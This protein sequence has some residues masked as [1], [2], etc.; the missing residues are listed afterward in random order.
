M[1]DGGFDIP[2]LGLALAEADRAWRSGKNKRWVREGNFTGLYIRLLVRAYPLH[3]TKPAKRASIREIAGAEIIE[4]LEDQL[5]S[6]TESIPHQYLAEFPLKISLPMGAARIQLSRDM[7]LVEVEQRVNVPHSASLFSGLSELATLPKVEQQTLLRVR[8]AGFFD[9]HAEDS[10]AHAALATLRQF[11]ALSM[12]S[13]E[14]EIDSQS[15]ATAIVR[16]SSVTRISSKV[17]S[18]ERS[19]ELPSNVQRML[20]RYAIAGRAFRNPS[21]ARLQGEGGLAMAAANFPVSENERPSVLK[22]NLDVLIRVLRAHKKDGENLRTAAEWLFDSE[23]EENET[24]ALLYASIGLEAVLDAPEGAVTARLADRLAWF[25]G[26]TRKERNALT[27]EY[28]NFYRVR[29]GLVHGRER[30]LDDDGRSKLLWARRT[31][32][33]V[34]SRE[35]E[36]WPEAVTSKAKKKGHAPG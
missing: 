28:Q 15:G 26:R 5:V 12:A 35:L 36:Q 7:E 13:G 20:S 9:G 11:V 21:N 17:V 19:F 8:V 10:A 2:T 29:S 33:S 34:I 22:K 27:V 1:P 32:R 14:M 25:L 30:R 31:L 18:R 24:T 3:Q 16:T 6:E 4:R 23:S